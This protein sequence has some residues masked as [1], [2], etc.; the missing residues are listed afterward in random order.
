MVN[1]KVRKMLTF[2]ISCYFTLS[3]RYLNFFFFLING[4][5][6]EKQEKKR[7]VECLLGQRDRRR[8]LDYLQASTFP[9]PLYK[10]AYF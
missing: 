9:S 4:I 6:F 8:M 7:P 3:N 10:I 5:Y 2:P 1:F